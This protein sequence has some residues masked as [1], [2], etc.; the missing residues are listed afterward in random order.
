MALPG[1]PERA[2]R[3]WLA[4]ALGLLV[5]GSAAAPAL[6]ADPSGSATL[7]RQPEAAV[8]FTWTLVAA[9]LVFFMQAG[10]ALL[11]AGLI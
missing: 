6:A 2:G 3:M 10:F 8:N 11:G 5:A 1:K 4:A 9:F 7:A